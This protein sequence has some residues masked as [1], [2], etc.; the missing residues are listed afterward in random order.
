MSIRLY[1][2]RTTAGRVQLGS[3]SARILFSLDGAL[4][5]SGHDKRISSD[6]PGSAPFMLSLFLFLSRVL[7]FM[8]SRTSAKERAGTAESPGDTR[9]SRALR[10]DFQY[11]LSLAISLLCCRCEERRLARQREKGSM[12]DFF[13]K[14]DSGKTTPTSSKFTSACRV[15][16]IFARD[17]PV[18]GD[19]TG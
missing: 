1:T 16:S 15:S 6:K 10:S 14:N 11:I 9:G 17:S 12:G 5:P 19:E 8:I 13:L 4:A 7:P 2:S 3:A 18:R